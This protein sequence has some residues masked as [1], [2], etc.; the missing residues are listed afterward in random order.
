[1]SRGDNLPATGWFRG[2][3]AAWALTEGPLAG[4]ER[5]ATHCQGIRET[6]RLF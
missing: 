3:R 6:V 2:R 5:L 4:R 1:M